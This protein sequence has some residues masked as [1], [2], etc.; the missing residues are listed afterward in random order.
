MPEQHSNTHGRE[1]AERKTPVQAELRVS[2]EVFR[3]MVEGV[4]DYAIFLLDVKGNVASWNIGAERIKGYRAEEIIGKHFSIFYPK[5][6]IKAG[7]PQRELE[8]ALSHGRTKVEGWRLRKD[9]SRF[10]ADITITALYDREGKLCGYSK[11]VRDI[12]DRRNADEALRKSRKMFE[13]L[14]ENAPD[15]VVVVDS[16]GII[17]KVNQQVETMFGYMREELLG[18]RVER[19][20]P[21]RFHQVHRQHRRGYFTDPRTRKMGAGLQLFGRNRDGWEIPVDIMLSPIETDEGLWAFAVIRD[22][23]QRKQD[24]EK[25]TELNTTLK[26]QVGQLA[27]SNR[28]LE[29]FSYSVSHDLRAPVRH[30]VGFL[31]LLNGRDLTSLDDKSRHYLQVISDAARKMGAL[32]D[33]LLTFSRMG[34]VEMMRASVDFSVLVQEVIKELTEEAKGREVAWEIGTLPVVVGDPAMLRQ[35][36]VNLIA[37]ALKFTRPRPQTRI[38]IGAITDHPQETVFYIRDNGV[39][40]D[41]KYVNKLFGV[42][43]RLHPTEEFEGTGI[44]LAN[45][46]RII[47]RHGGRIWAEGAVDGGAAFWFTLPKIGAGVA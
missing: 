19:L 45:V 10:W 29:A 9:R 34:R 42:F 20:I 23:T 7:G 40:F 4:R 44:G 22:I 39:G 13:R 24:E 2:D 38:E 6:D 16:D 1:T 28:E 25:I 26:N 31:E 27:A 18:D 46:Q 36:M 33:D 11:V 21:E 47:L 17:R 37:N 41:M 43:Q 5:E 14:F 12:T 3:L 8:T 15:A 30:I 32:I 35:V